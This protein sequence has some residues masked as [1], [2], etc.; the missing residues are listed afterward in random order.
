MLTSDQADRQRAP[1]QAESLQ[2]SFQQ[3]IDYWTPILVGMYPE[4]YEDALG[5]LG[6]TLAN[7]QVA[8]MYA[9]SA[10]SPTYTLMQDYLRNY[11]PQV[12]NL[13]KQAQSEYALIAQWYGK[14]I[15]S[16][17]PSSSSV[18]GSVG[19]AINLS[20]DTD[21]PGGT[22]SVFYLPAGLAFDPTTGTIS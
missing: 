3:A 6:S 20:F 13:L 11:L 2:S 10:S 12:T 21:G 17:T 22:Y 15:P 1:S 4:Y 14:T 19:Q 5:G 7:A 8:Y 9:R 16:L 18:N